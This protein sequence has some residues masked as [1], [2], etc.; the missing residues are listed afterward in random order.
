MSRDRDQE[1]CAEQL[2]AR[3]RQ[4][5][6]LSQ[7][8]RSVVDDDARPRANVAAARRASRRLVASHRR[9]A[10]DDGASAVCFCVVCVACLNFRFSSTVIC[11]S[12]RTCAPT[13]LL[14]AS[15]TTPFSS[16]S[17]CR[18]LRVALLTCCAARNV[19]GVQR[20]AHRH[21]S[22]LAA[23][24]VGRCCCR[25]A[26]SFVNGATQVKDAKFVFLS[27]PDREVGLQRTEAE[28]APKSAVDSALARARQ[29][30]SAL[31][32]SICFVSIKRNRQRP[33]AS[34]R[35][36]RRR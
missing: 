27:A 17:A 14:G 9:L 25:C 31:S 1:S 5:G 35:C 28:Q 19:D 30:A 18:V 36:C 33:N 8:A 11:S 3:R 7:L 34:D 4:H 32:V 12:C 22:R 6:A 13:R 10:A 20:H 23:S 16:R 24:S 15:S 2:C 26:Q 29:G 21:Q